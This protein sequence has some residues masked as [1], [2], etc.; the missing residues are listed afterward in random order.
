MFHQRLLKIE[1]SM[2][3]VLMELVYYTLNLGA[4]LVKAI[5]SKMMKVDLVFLVNQF[6]FQLF[7]KMTCALL[8]SLRKKLLML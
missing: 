1:L 3:Q 4:A 2:N 8:F 6:H 7:Q 5:L